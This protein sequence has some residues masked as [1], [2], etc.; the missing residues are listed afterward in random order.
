MTLARDP[1][2]SRARRDR[3]TPHNVF[4][5]AR[6]SFELERLVQVQ[7]HRGRG[8]H[9]TLAIASWLWMLSKFLTFTE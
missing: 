3:A 4:G 1:L 5:T 9:P 2:E 7:C 6:D 8:S